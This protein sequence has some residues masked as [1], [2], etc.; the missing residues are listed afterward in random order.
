M[1]LGIIADDF[2]GATDLAVTLV[3]EG[4]SV[5][6]LF[7]TPDAVP[8]LTGIDAAVI[9]LKS[10]TIAPELAV[11]QSVEA[12][13]WLTQQ[14]AGQIFFKYCSTFDSTDQG[15]IGPVADALMDEL[16]AE[17]ALICPAFPINGRSVYMGHLFVGQELLSDSPMRHHPLTP[18]TDSS[19]VRLMTAQS[20]KRV[21]LVSHDHVKNGAEAIEEKL[22]KLALDGCGYA[23]ADAIDNRDLRAIGRAAQFHKLITGGS[24]VAMGLPANFG[25]SPSEAATAMPRVAGR[26]IVLAGSCSVATRGQIAFVKDRWPVMKLDVD[27]IAAGEDV[28]GAAVDWANQRPATAP[29]LIYAS[30]D[31][32]E[33]AA[34]QARYGVEKAGAMVEETFANI[35]RTL[36]QTGFGRFVVAGGETSGAVVSGLDIRALKICGEIDPGVPWTQTTDGTEIAL[37]LKSGN[38]GTP[39]FFEKAFARLA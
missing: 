26:E 25:I 9:A 36:S 16:D 2:T 3:N 27:A 14:G 23:V 38:F 31:P 28:A 4:M 11:G 21:G 34:T 12:C 19:L 15:N 18:M 39:D 29:A 22:I 13:R 33:V 10:R 30:A 24:G 32:D 6:Q 7:G 35:A 37:A 1:K 20:R 5:L 17:I 8:D